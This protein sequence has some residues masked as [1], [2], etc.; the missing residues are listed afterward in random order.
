M[1]C[2]Y[3][4]ILG[5]PKQGVHSK[6]IFGLSLNDIIATIIAAAITSYFMK[7][8]FGY[9]LIVWVVAGEI[10]HYIFGVQSEFLTQIGITVHC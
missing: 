2:P 3:S 10:L 4:Q 8:N 7:V 9:S 6:R 1:P 5:I